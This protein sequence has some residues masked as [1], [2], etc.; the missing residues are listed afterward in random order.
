[1][2]RPGWER[3]DVALTPTELL[4]IDDRRTFAFDDIINCAAG[5]TVRLCAFFGS[6][7]LRPAGHRRHNRAA[8]LRV[9]IFQCYA[10]KWAPV[11]TPQRAKRGPSLFPRIKQERRGLGRFLHPGG[12]EL[13]QTVHRF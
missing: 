9:A 4:A 3:D 13:A 8:S 12:V 10:V 6:E 11:L 2:Q 5:M 7:Q 1:M